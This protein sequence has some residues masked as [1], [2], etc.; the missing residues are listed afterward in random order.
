[1]TALSFFVFYIGKTKQLGNE[2]M[3]FIEVNNEK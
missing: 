3:S 2:Q 1:M